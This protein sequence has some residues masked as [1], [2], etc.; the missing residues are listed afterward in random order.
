MDNLEKLDKFVGKYTSRLN[1]EEIKNINTPITSNEIE[2]MIKNLPIERARWRRSRWT[3]SISLS[4]DT[5][6]IH[7]QTQ[8]C[9]QN[10]N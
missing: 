8:K 1:Q 4:T 9:V 5:S 10:A 3:L 2:T 6:G 7:L